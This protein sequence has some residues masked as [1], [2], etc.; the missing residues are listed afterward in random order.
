L[1]QIIERQGYALGEMQSEMERPTFR[2]LWRHELK[3]RPPRSPQ[4]TPPCIN[5]PQD[6]AGEVR[7]V[8]ADTAG[9]GVPSAVDLFC[10]VA[11]AAGLWCTQKNDNPVTQGS[12]FSISEICLSAGPIDYT[13]MESPDVI[14][15]VSDDGWKELQANGTLAACREET[16]LFMDSQIAA[17]PPAGR[18]VRLPLRRNGNPKHAALTAVAAWLVKNPVLPWEAWEA[19]L[20]TEPPER[21]A[22]LTIALETGRRLACEGV[23]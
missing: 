17:R 2:E 21:R 3:S 16:L 22:E 5:T 6:L 23:A 14:L 1:Q 18:V 9:E 8:V 13:G 11:L 15:A 7:V 10:R 12:G 20:A 4:P 19:V